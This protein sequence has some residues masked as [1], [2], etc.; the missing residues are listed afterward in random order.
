MTSCSAFTTSFP[1][2]Q[3]RLINEAYII[4]GD[5]Q[6]HTDVA[7]WDTGATKTCISSSVIDR[8]GLIPIG[9]T[10]VMT[11]T[12][13]KNSCLIHRRYTLKKQCYGQGHHGNRVRDRWSRY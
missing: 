5:E 11:P 3:D 7:Q 6:M 4:S 1:G 2:H 10:M 8:L 12:G 13:E 9:Q